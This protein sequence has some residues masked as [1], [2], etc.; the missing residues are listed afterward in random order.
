[1]LVPHSL[2]TD[3]NDRSLKR[4]H[5]VRA[6]LFTDNGDGRSSSQPHQVRVFI[7]LQESVVLRPMA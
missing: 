7:S 3:P 4:G 6:T 1:M 5:R 2:S